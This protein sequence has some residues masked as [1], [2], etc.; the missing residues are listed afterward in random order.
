MTASIS[1]KPSAL[2]LSFTVIRS[3]G[4]ASTFLSHRSVWDIPVSSLSLLQKC[5]L[6]KCII[7]YFLSIWIFSLLHGAFPV[8]PPVSYPL[9]DLISTFLDLPWHSFPLLHSVTL[10]Y[11]LSY[12]FLQTFHGSCHSKI[13]RI[14]KGGS[15]SVL[16]CILMLPCKLSGIKKACGKHWVELSLNF[17]SEERERERVGG[18]LWWQVSITLSIMQ[19]KNLLAIILQRWINRLKFLYNL[20]LW[21]LHSRVSCLPFCFPEAKAV[22]A[23]SWGCALCLFLISSPLCHCRCSTFLQKHCCR[24]FPFQIFQGLPT[25]WCLLSQGQ[26]SWAGSISQ[27]VIAREFSGFQNQFVGDCL[28]LVDVKGDSEMTWWNCSKW[29]MW[30][31]QQSPPRSC[32]CHLSSGCYCGHTSTLWC[33]SPKQHAVFIWFIASCFNQWVSRQCVPRIIEA[34]DSV[35]HPSASEHVLA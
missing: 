5:L 27:S 21:F 29:Q 13:T 12:I 31:L 19:E 3:S 32:Q 15:M 23:H 6:T 10:D 16:F 2:Q 28:L 34:D 1:I 9:L 20:H 35:C 4:V 14:P 17:S 24:F 25:M 26:Q 11:I 22:T 33:S 18:D 7:C 8:L 30:H